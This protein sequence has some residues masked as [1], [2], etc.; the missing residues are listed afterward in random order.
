MKKDYEY[1]LFCRFSAIAKK[2]VIASSLKEAIHIVESEQLVHFEEIVE[3][4]EPCKVDEELTGKFNEA[5][6]FNEFHEYKS[7]GSE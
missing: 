1:M 6:E 4:T 7:W 5:L 3:L 2:K